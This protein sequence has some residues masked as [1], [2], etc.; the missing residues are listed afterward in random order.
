MRGV[1]SFVFCDAPY[2]RFQLRIRGIA[3]MHITQSRG[4][5]KSSFFQ[6]PFQRGFE[7]PKFILSEVAEGLSGE[8]TTDCGMSRERAKIYAEPP[9]LKDLEEFRERM[10]SDI[11][12]SYISPLADRFEASV[13]KRRKRG[14]AC[15][16]YD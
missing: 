16:S 11:D 15:S 10:P 4:E 8:R 13:E 2:K 9:R 5:T 14:S 12:A 1:D 6:S 7:Y 3:A